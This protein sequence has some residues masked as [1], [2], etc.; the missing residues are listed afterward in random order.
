MDHDDGKVGAN[1]VKHLEHGESGDDL[2]G[3]DHASQEKGLEEAGPF[4]FNTGEDESTQCGRADTGDQH[5][6]GDNDAVHHG[7]KDFARSR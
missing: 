6:Q 3:S 5:T 2:Q 7:Q 1:Q 4:A